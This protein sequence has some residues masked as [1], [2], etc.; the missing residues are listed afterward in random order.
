MCQSFNI[1]H[2]ICRIKFIYTRHFIK[3]FIS[4]DLKLKLKFK[5]ITKYTLLGDCEIDNNNNYI[6]NIIIL[7]VINYKNK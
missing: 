3:A 6:N 5:S 1:S 4:T 2:I 7:F